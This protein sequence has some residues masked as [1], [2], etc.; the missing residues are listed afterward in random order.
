MDTITMAPKASVEIPSNNFYNLR[1]IIHDF[2]TKENLKLSANTK[3]QI[4]K[5]VKMMAQCYLDKFQAWMQAECAKAELKGFRCNLWSGYIEDESTSAYLKEID[6]FINAAESIVSK[7]KAYRDYAL[8]LNPD[9]SEY[10]YINGDVI[11]R[12]LREEQENV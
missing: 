2:R 3:T 8:R 9:E 6:L 10:L 12:E 4:R 11:I 1:E 5:S 7:L